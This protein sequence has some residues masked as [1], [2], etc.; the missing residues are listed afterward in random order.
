M[1]RAPEGRKTDGFWGVASGN[2]TLGGLLGGEKCESRRF[3]HFSEAL[4]GKADESGR[5]LSGTPLARTAMHPVCT[6]VRRACTR[7][8]LR[9]PQTLSTLCPHCVHTL[10]TLCSVRPHGVSP[11]RSRRAVPSLQQLAHDTH[12]RTHTRT[13]TTHTHARTH[14]HAYACTHTH[15]HTHT[16]LLL[17]LLPA[18]ISLRTTRYLGFS[19]LRTC[20]TWGVQG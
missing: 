19:R 8:R 12:T 20:G 7:G 17:L 5:P 4:L 1:S 6:H 13:R 16:H 11:A 14:A 10:P 15:T 2:Q 3:S 9:T 18:C